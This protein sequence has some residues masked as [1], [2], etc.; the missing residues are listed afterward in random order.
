[1]KTLR[2]SLWGE[3]NHKYLAMLLKENIKLLDKGVYFE[4]FLEDTLQ[5]LLLW[6]FRSEHLF[7]PSMLSLVNWPNI[8][9]FKFR[10]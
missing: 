4:Y 2:L 8:A 10:Q 6:L 9:Y 5:Q 1:M 7:L 3:D